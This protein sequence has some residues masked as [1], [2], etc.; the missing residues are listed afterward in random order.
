MRCLGVDAASVVQRVRQRQ[1]RM[2]GH[3]RQR[4]SLLFHRHPP[5][6]RACRLERFCAGRGGR[7]PALPGKT[8]LA[9]VVPTGFLAEI[10]APLPRRS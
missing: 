1:N 5:D 4:G 10:R 3:E 7:V 8:L 2:D 6:R 9:K